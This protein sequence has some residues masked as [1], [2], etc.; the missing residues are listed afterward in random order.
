MAHIPYWLDEPQQTRPPLR[1]D[2][3]TDVLVIGGG[4]CGTSALLYLAEQGLNPVLIDSRNI[5]QAATGRN[6]GFI[7]QGTAERYSRAIATLGH[8]RAQAIH[9]W[10]LVNH[11]RIASR[12]EDYSIECGYA[13]NGSLQLANSP[14]EEADLQESMRLLQADGFSAEWL[15]E[16]DLGPGYT[17]NGFRMGLLLPEDGELHP[18]R[19][20]QGIAQAA[21]NLGATI[22]PETPALSITENIDGASVKTPSGQ[23]AAQVVLVCTNAYTP[24]LLPWFKDKIDP[25]RG[26]MLATAPAPKLFDRPIY[27]DHGYDYWRQDENGC[28]VLGGWRNLDPDA[29]VGF[30]ERLNPDIQSA[31]T[32]FIQQ[33]PQLKDTP[34]SHRWSGI[35]GFSVDGLPILG[36]PPGMNSVLVAAGFTGHGFGFAQ[37]AGEAIAEV[38]IEGQHPFVDALSARRFL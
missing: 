14:S 27:A 30:D 16:N 17:E 20:V 33:F 32:R 29:E 36:A 34:I 26:Q 7:L 5:A 4:L 8:G 12:I 28:I 38:A 21:V 19:Y 18:A 22:Y 11:E 3:Q 23:I 24:T 15:T 37:L 9:R 25:V 35:M 1:Q 31:M 13:K 6:A 10:S 2:L